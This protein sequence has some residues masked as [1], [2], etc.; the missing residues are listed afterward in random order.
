MGSRSPDQY[1]TNRFKKCLLCG[2]E[3]EDSV[4]GLKS[5][6]CMQHKRQFRRNK[7]V[8]FKTIKCDECGKEITTKMYNQRFCSKRC[9][10]RYLDRSLY[11]NNINAKLAKILRI[12]LRLSL[13]DKPHKSVLKYLGCSLSELKVH[14]ELQ[15]EEDMTWDNY[16]SYSKHIKRWNIDHIK[17]LSKFDLSN[18]EELAKACHY[19]NLRPM[20]A[21]DN[22]IKNNKYNED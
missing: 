16:G 17:P 18:E 15:F 7:K 11:K 22:L 3:F 12:R 6:C 13:K 4:N 19:T 5:F 10:C 20:W 9:G 8:V 1:K 21:I 14:L 2:L